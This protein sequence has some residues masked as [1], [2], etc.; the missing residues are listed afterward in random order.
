MSINTMPLE[1]ETRILIDRNLENLG[2]KLL[3]NCLVKEITLYDDKMIITYNTPLNEGSDE[4]RGFSFYEKMLY[5]PY[6]VPQSGQAISVP[7]YTV[8]KV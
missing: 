8:M 2:W 7:I 1:A 3:I 5:L 6:T 4:N